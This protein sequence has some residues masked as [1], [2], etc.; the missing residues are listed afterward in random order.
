MA[1]EVT[2]SSNREQ[3]VVCLRWVDKLS[4][5]VNEDLIGLYQVDDITA[6]TL[7]SSLK[8]VLLRMNISLHNCRAQC[9]DGASNM[10]GARSGV[11]TLIQKEEPRAILVHCY[12]HSLQLAVSD[13]VKQIKPMSDALD[14][15]NEISKLLKYSPKRDTLFE[16]I[17]KELAP[18]TPGFRVLCPTRW[19]V[20]ANS[21]Q[22]VIDN[23]LP[24]LELWD[25]CLTQKN[26][27]SEIKSR[28]IG[29][30]H[31]MNTFDYFFGT[32]LGVLLLKHSDNQ[33]TF[34]SATEGQSVSAMTVSTLKLIRS[35]EQFEAFWALVT[36]KAKDLE[37]G[38]PVLPRKRKQPVR[39]EDGQAQPYFP[40]SPKALYKSVYFNSLDIIIT[41]IENRFDQPG[42]H[43]LRQLEALLL[44]AVNKDNFSNELE[45]VSH[46]YDSEIDR[47]LLET[48]LHTL[49]AYFQQSSNHTETATL[50]DLKEFMANLTVSQKSLISQAVF[51][52]KMVLFAPATNAVSERSCSALRRTK[53]WLRTTMNQ[54]RLNHCLLLHAHQTLTDQI[55]VES[56]A[57]EFIEGNERRIHSF[58]RLS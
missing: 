21:L 1:D 57:A 14:T 40:E 52:Y 3:F 56:V 12:G 55:N 9:Y 35:D 22:S 50:K 5:A 41:C 17:K 54:D 58:G 43:I 45:L 19:T 30:K 46:F 4:F 26:L 36:L 42:Y 27:N 39:Y 28:I 34:M 11:A 44:K 10:V 7:F 6:A 2:D 31:Q 23:W 29:V 49:S 47:T 8:D 37:I 18:D 25:E 15:T 32:S 38:E 16:K 48:H 24:L 33:H 20:R 53:T 13:T 51:V